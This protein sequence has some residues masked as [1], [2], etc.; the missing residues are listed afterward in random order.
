[1]GSGFSQLGAP[2][3]RRTGTK[4]RAQRGIM[5][6]ISDEVM[7][8]FLV[9]AF[10]FIKAEIK[11]DGRFLF[12]YSAFRICRIYRF[13]A[14][15]LNIG[16]PR[17]DRRQIPVVALLIGV[18]KD[19]EVGIFAFRVDCGELLGCFVNVPYEPIEDRVM[20]QA[21]DQLPRHGGFQF[22]IKPV[23]VL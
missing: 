23:I 16:V 8:S 11:I 21:T 10:R 15:A 14:P 17:H 18:H 1:L 13:Y 12:L 3:L 5:R 7:E 6:S 4:Q 22:F 9:F 19:E 20:A 2:M